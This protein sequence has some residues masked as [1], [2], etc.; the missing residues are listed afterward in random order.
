MANSLREV[1]SRINSTRNTAQITKAMYMVSQSKVKKAE[2]SYKLYK[3]FMARI[4]SMV[5]DIS[6]RASEDYPH[7][8]LKERE[9]K[10]TAYLIITSD[11]GLAGAYNS[12]IYKA[13][14]E[15]IDENHKSR[16]EYIVTSIGKLGYSFIKRK[17]YNTTQK[18]ALLVRDDVQFFDIQPLARS[19]IDLYIKGEIDKFVIIYNHYVNSL[20]QEV[21]FEQLLP[22]DKLENNKGEIDY[23]YESGIEKTLDLILPMYVEDI[24]YGVILDAKCAEH[25]ARMNAMRSAT[26]NAEEVIDKLQ[27][28]Y[29]RARQAVVTNE[30]IDIIGG[31]NAIGG[32]D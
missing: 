25:S 26:D 20:T 31:A 29:N 11:R 15:K 32:D 28:L 7:K 5:S 6:S 22:I 30:L 4:S 27:L 17:K 8:L 21:K 24:V 12:N 14:E 9:I 13:I 3:D 1:K 2:K 16:N 18:K 10:K 19:I 23:V